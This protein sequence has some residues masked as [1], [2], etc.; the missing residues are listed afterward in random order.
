MKKLTPILCAALM[1]GPVLAKNG[2][3]ENPF[4]KNELLIVSEGKILTTGKRLNKPA[5]FGVTKEYTITK[6]GKYLRFYTS[7]IVVDDFEIN[8]Q[9][10]K[11]LDNI[12]RVKERCNRTDVD[13]VLLRKNCLKMLDRDFF[14]EGENHISE[15]A[16]G[17]LHLKFNEVDSGDNGIKISALES[18]IKEVK[19]N[20]KDKENS[21]LLKVE[22][23]EEEYQKAPVASFDGD[24]LYGFNYESGLVY[25]KYR[26][27]L[28]NKN[29]KSY[30]D[31]SILNYSPTDITNFKV[32]SLSLVPTVDIFDGKIQ[33]VEINSELSLYKIEGAQELVE[34]KD[35]MKK[36]MFKVLKNDLKRSTFEKLQGYTVTFK[37]LL[38]RYEEKVVDEV[39]EMSLSAKFDDVEK[40]A[41][42][43]AFKQVSEDDLTSEPMK[44]IRKLKIKK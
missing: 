10:N 27:G 4:N 3:V 21:M 13:P 5:N 39:V 28:N 25:D 30:N 29:A 14:G 43:Y 7:S 40:H 32:M 6:P 20:Y 12:E 36:D 24:L 1:A 19:F 35:A 34:I 9:K 11:F 8:Y 42:D 2:I 41:E 33:E 38:E 37:E 44:L 23:L 15:E 22:E 16:H 31:F 26:A 18:K 17:Y